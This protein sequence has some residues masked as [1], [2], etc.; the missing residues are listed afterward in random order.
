MLPG[1]GGKEEIGDSPE[2]GIE[3]SKEDETEA[4]TSQNETL[5]SSA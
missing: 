2:T 4:E 1:W 5:T 3:R